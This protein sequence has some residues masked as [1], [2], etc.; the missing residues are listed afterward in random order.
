MVIGKDT[1]KKNYIGI[2]EMTNEN[3][4]TIQDRVSSVF[5]SILYNLVPS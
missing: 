1:H 2:W 3:Y 5:V 4:S